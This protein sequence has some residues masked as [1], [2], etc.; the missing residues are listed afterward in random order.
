MAESCS[1]TPQVL[2]TVTR[3]FHDSGE[4]LHFPQPAALGQL[5]FLNPAWLTSMMAQLITFKP[6]GVKNVSP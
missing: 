4:L 6:N 3:F 2:P 1:I 5:V